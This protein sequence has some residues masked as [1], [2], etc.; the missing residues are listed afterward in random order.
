M[1]SAQYGIEEEVYL[2]HRGKPSLESFYCLAS[3]LW[4]KGFFNY[5]HTA[6]NLSHASDIKTGIMGGI[7]VSTEICGDAASA[8]GA[9]ARR[10]G[11]L[12]EAADSGLI[13]PMGSLADI[14]APTKTC[15]MHIHVGGLDSIDRAYTNIARFLPLLML[16]TASSPC[17]NGRRYGNSYRAGKCPFIGPLNGNRLDRFQDIIVSRRLKTIEIRIFDT[18]WDMDRIK[19]LMEILDKIVKIDKRLDYNPAFY[20]EAREESVSSGYGER[21][22]ELYRELNGFFSCREELFKDTPSDFIYDYI[23]ANGRDAAYSALDNCYR[24]RVFE[25]ASTDGQAPSP[26][27]I[28]IG[29]AGYFV[30]KIPYSVWKTCRELGV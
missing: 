4:K 28:G 5:A 24:N 19:I 12:S 10:R 18:V 9:L 2:V 1:E 3:L 22:A 27:K 29:L 21:T 23:K 14:E 8:A 20:R 7:E 26:F 11:E 17:V 15:G 16:L 13:I 6:V 25:P 30:P